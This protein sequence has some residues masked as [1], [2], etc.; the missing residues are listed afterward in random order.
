MRPWL[1]WNKSMR[2]WPF[3]ESML[4]LRWNQLHFIVRGPVCS[5]FLLWSR[6]VQ[7]LI[8]RVEFRSAWKLRPSNS[9]EEM[10]FG[11]A[12]RLDYVQIEKPVSSK[13]HC[14]PAKTGVLLIAR[15][16]QWLRLG[17]I[18]IPCTESCS[19]RKN[20][21]EQ[22]TQFFV[23]WIVEGNQMQQGADPLESQ[24]HDRYLPSFHFREICRQ[25]YCAANQ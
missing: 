9:W 16:I 15:N 20:L 24:Y 8:A 19:N 18:E 11:V 12:R 22:R 23:A 10:S 5:L 7:V 6:P 3:E 21:D 4:C 2:C 14:R 1:C 13:G 25:R 17:S